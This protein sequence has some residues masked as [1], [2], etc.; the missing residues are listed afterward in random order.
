MSREFLHFFFFLACSTN[1]RSCIIEKP[2]MWFHLTLSRQSEHRICFARCSQNKHAS[3]SSKRL[4]RGEGRSGRESFRS[5]LS[6]KWAHFPGV[7]GS[8]Y[9][10][11]P[12]HVNSSYRVMEWAW[13]PD[14]WHPDKLF[15]SH[16]PWYPHL[17]N[18]HHPYPHEIIESRSSCLR[19]TKSQYLAYFN[20]QILVPSHLQ[21]T[22][23][24]KHR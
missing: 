19:W 5:L 14:S 21:S 6:G 12:N 23:T 13:P 24:D 3:H 17:R 9:V 18:G 16:E 22:I 2:K 1:P 15:C 8:V 10:F 4:D 11:Y 20:A 7:Q